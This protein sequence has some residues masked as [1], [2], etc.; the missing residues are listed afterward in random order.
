MATKTT[1]AKRTASKAK[2]TTSKTTT[3]KTKASAPKAEE[4]TD[5]AVMAIE[6]AE[7]F[8]G[9]AQEQYLSFVEQGQEAALRGITSVRETVSNFEMPAVPGL[10]AVTP[11][12]EI[13]TKQLTSLS[14]SMHDFAIKAIQSQKAFAKKVLAASTK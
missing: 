2:A 4:T 3:S 6:R 13:P 11:E 7:E 9:K 14:D 12:F 5:F 1:S 10:D 8:T